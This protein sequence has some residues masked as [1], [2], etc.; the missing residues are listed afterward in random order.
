MNV[1]GVENYALSQL[2]GGEGWGEGEAPLGFK[3]QKTAPLPNPPRKRGEGTGFP[4][5][6][7][8]PGAF[9]RL[10]TRF[11]N[12]GKM[13]NCLVKLNACFFAFLL[14]AAPLLHLWCA[15][16]CATRESAAS[17]DSCHEER[18][19]SPEQT[20]LEP[21]HDCLHR[22]APAAAVV[23]NRLQTLGA[24]AALP[25]ESPHLKIHRPFEISQ[26]VF[27][28]GSSAGVLVVPLRV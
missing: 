28:L 19:Q 1:I 21:L 12:T 13:K 17:R 9:C 20:T 26:T 14:V 18:A 3:A 15:V 25:L 5:L 8:C 7:D 27:T 2:V 4:P 22:A 6:C 23:A 10:F 16:G 24:L 11:E